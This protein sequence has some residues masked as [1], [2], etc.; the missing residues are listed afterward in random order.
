MPGE[1]CKLIH[2]CY[3]QPDNPL[4]LMDMRWTYPRIYFYL[5]T[6]MHAHTI[7]FFFSLS[8]LTY[9]SSSVLTPTH[10]LLRLTLFYL[11]FPRHSLIHFF[12]ST[13]RKRPHTLIYIFFSLHPKFFHTHTHIQL[14]Y[15]PLSSVYH[16]HANSHSCLHLSHTHTH[17]LSLIQAPPLPPHTL[18]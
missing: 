1:L 7:Y 5:L 4:I 3:P 6:H 13:E 17:L 11:P 9:L 8:C 12:S 18:R 14:L 10:L 15:S 16:A 2:P